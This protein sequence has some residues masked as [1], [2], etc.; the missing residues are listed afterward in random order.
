LRC[1]SHRITKLLGSEDG[2]HYG[3]FDVGRA[4]LAPG[5]TVTLKWDKS[6][7][8]SRCAW[9][10]KAVFDDGSETEPKKFDFCEQ[11]LE[12]DF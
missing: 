11:D 2:E 1:D 4:G 6:T 9:F 12:L 7:N 8:N 5:G 3:S 10:I